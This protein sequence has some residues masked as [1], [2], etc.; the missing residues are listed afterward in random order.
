MRE[1]A[2]VLVIPMSFPLLVFQARVE[3][4]RL[5]RVWSL[6]DKKGWWYTWSL[7]L[8]CY[9]ASLSAHARSTDCKFRRWFF[10]IRTKT[11]WRARM[12][13][14]SARSRWP[15]FSLRFCWGLWSASCWLIVQSSSTALPS[16]SFWKCC[17]PLHRVNLAGRIQGSTALFVK[18][19]NLIVY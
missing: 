19:L 11:S 2:V 6:K 17:S 1:L 15:T 9:G 18:G 12:A 3:S 8:H 10:Q 7:S 13:Q 5:A 4:V 14:P 16:S